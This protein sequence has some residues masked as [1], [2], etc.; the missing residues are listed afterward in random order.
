LKQ[1]NNKLRKL[2]GKLLGNLQY[3]DLVGLLEN[4][5]HSNESIDLEE[6]IVLLSIHTAPSGFLSSVGSLSDHC[7][8]YGSTQHPPSSM[9]SHAVPT[10]Q[11]HVST[12]ARP[13]DERRTVFSNTM[14]FLP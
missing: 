14:L 6:A 5:R 1:E 3:E 13:T 10:V 11:L 4:I 7:E 9:A 2:L 12:N 8:R